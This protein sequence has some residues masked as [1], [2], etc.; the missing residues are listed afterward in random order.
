MN[1]PAAEPRGIRRMGTMIISPNPAL[2]HEGRE[3]MV[4]PKQSFEESID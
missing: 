3:N 1:Y 2:S 4:T